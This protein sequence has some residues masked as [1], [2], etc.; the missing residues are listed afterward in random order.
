MNEQFR[1]R[2]FKNQNEILVLMRSGWEL[3]K[4]K[5]TGR[6]WIEE[7]GIGSG[8]N[9]VIIHGN[10]FNSLYKKGIIVSTGNGF[11]IELFKI[12]ESS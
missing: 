4:C 5:L 9:T 8:N 6:K 2:S 1:S 7:G 3:G 12:T 11:P 10:M